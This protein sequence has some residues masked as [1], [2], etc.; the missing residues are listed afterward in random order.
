MWSIR[1]TERDHKNHGESNPTRTTAIANAPEAMYRLQRV[2]AS[3]GSEISNDLWLFE[4]ARWQELVFALLTRICD[5]EEEH[6]RE[7]VDGLND[8]GLLDTVALADLFDDQ[9]HIKSKTR[10]SQRI[11][12]HL[13]DNNFSEAQAMN[14]LK[15]MGEAALGL[16]EH[17]EGK[18]QKYL[19]WFGELMLNDVQRVFTFSVLSEKDVQQVF[20]YWLQN[21]MNMPL[22]LN[23]ENVAAFC[24]KHNIS[25]DELFRAADELDLNLAL[26][27]DLVQSYMEKAKERSDKGA[28]KGK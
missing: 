16:Q 4:D 5:L 23:D 2:L 14:A 24:T 26:V 9:R 3:E 28:K 25:A 7:T 12:G 8:L 13:T 27:D 20:T 22:S 18:V 1:G 10:Y 15:C 17:Y 19:R 11:L 21:V 6:L